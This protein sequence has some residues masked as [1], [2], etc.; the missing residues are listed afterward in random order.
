[1][2]EEMRET[3]KRAS[4]LM[5]TRTAEPEK[6]NIRKALMEQLL[7]VAGFKKEE[8]EKINL[9]EISEEELQNTI[10]QKL[11][12]TMSANGSRQ[13]VIPIGDVKSYI[14]QGF[15]YVDSLPNG[16]AIVKIP[17]L[18]TLLPIAR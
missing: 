18:K 17:F 2:V 16:E 1:M 3:Y 13:R 12:G 4:S 10:R 6:E 5:Q 9:D 14:A 8:V 7:L 15:E 11:I